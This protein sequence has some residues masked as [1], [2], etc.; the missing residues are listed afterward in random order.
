M[1]FC[2][3]LQYKTVLNIATKCIEYWMEKSHF[4]IRNTD[5]S[6][7]V[8]NSRKYVA[9]FVQM[10][11]PVLDFFFFTE[12]WVVCDDNAMVRYV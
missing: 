3:E 4:G 8:K 10:L 9:D 7:N 12:W 1:F 2:G 6:W 11:L 5:S